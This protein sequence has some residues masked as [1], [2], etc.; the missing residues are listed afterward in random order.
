[1][2]LFLALLLVP[3]SDASANVQWDLKM[4]WGPTE[5]HPGEDAMFIIAVQ[6]S[7]TTASSGQIKIVDHL[8]LGVTFKEPFDLEDWNCFG[9]TT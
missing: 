5:L 7:G 3:A 8:P 2:A 4:I 9:T 6:N 1:M